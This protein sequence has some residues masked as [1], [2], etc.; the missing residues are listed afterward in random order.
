MSVITELIVAQK[1]DIQALLQA[2]DPSKQWTSFLC[3]G[4]DPMMVSILYSFVKEEIY[5]DLV[6]FSFQN[7][8][9]PPD[10]PFVE[11]FSKDMADTFANIQSDKIDSLAE[12]WLDTDELQIGGWTKP[13]AVT[14]IQ[15]LIKFS[16]ISQSE[17]AELFLWMVL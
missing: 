4:V 12:K 13:D 2:Q 8:A 15:N 10:G 1:Q 7:H 11:Q 9:I 6:H 16:Q 17:K 14:F 5:D 3:K